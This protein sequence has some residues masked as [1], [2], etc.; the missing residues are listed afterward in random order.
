MAHDGGGVLAPRWERYGRSPYLPVE[1]DQV[2]TLELGVMVE[3]CGYLGLEEM[4]LVTVDGCTWLS[5]R[6][7]ALAVIG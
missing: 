3:G 5:E 4:V 2:Y 6:Q 7:D 1:L